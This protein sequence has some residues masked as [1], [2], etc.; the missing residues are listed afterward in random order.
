[1]GYPVYAYVATCNIEPVNGIIHVIRMDHT[2]GFSRTALLTKAYEAG[3]IYPAPATQAAV[4]KTSE[5]HL[6]MNNH[7]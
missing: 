6:K 7:E 3:I 4:G 2:I 5:N 1:M